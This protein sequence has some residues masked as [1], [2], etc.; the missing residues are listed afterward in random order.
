MATGMDCPNLDSDLCV[1]QMVRYF[2]G[3]DYVTSLMIKP[4]NIL[5]KDNLDVA[6]PWSI[7]DYQT[8]R[9][10]GQFASDLAVYEQAY[11]ENI[12]LFAEFQTNLETYLENH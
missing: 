10:N 9:E 8:A 11:N 7:E 1:Q 3:E 5:T 2:N 6:I 4:S 12:D